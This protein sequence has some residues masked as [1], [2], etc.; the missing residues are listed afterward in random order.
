MNLFAQGKASWQ[1][2]YMDTVSVGATIN[3]MIAVVK[4]K[5]RIKVIENAAVNRKLSMLLP[6]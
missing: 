3:T 1:V 4:A 2:A 6:F 5:G